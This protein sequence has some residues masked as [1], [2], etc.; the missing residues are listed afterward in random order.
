MESK[1]SL[2]FYKE[3]DE[4]RIFE[5]WQA[6]YP[7]YNRTLE[8]W[9]RWWRWKYKENPAGTARIFLAEY[10]SKIVGQQSMVPMVMKIGAEVATC[11]QWVDTVTHPAY[12]RQGISFALYTA[13]IHQV[14]EDVVRLVYGFPNE[15]THRIGLLVGAVDAARIPYV[16]KPL[17]WGNALNTKISNKSFLKFLAV[18]GKVVS[19]T[20]RRPKEAPTVEGLTI[21]NVSSFDERINILWEKVSGQYPM[22]VVRN[23]GYLNWRYVAVPDMNYTIYTAEKEGEINGY[24]VLRCMEMNQIKVGAIFDILAQQEEITQCLISRAI[25]HCK[26]EGVDL[27]YGTM[28]ASKTLLKA[29]RRNGFMCTPFV[30]GVWL[31]AFSISQDIPKEFLTN[32][33]NWFVQKGDSDRL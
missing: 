15:A 14:K 21:S 20:F 7:Q 6:V 10:E 30:K 1:W 12:R 2:R 8:H 19:E 26:Q 25:D 23:E 17:D 29:L 9:L 3:G 33:K 28:L 18:G 16:F 4:E 11:F 31:Q 32:A 22:L 13:G 24:L 5:L 27:L